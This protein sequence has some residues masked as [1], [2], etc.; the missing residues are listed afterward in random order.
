[1]T[2]ELSPKEKF[3]ANI[4]G[5]LLGVLLGGCLAFYVTMVKAPISELS[6]KVQMLSDSY[7][8]QLNQEISIARQ[9][10]F[11]AQQ[12]TKVEFLTSVVEQGNELLEDE[13]TPDEKI[14]IGGANYLREEV[15]TDLQSRQERLE[16]SAAQIDSTQRAI[17]RMQ[18]ALSNLKDLT[19]F[20]VNSISGEE[21]LQAQ[22]VALHSIGQLPWPTL[23][24]SASIEGA[25]K[26]SRADFD[27]RLGLLGQSSS[28]DLGDL[29]AFLEE[30]SVSNF[31]WREEIA[32]LNAV[33]KEVESRKI[34]V[35]FSN[36][37]RLGFGTTPAD[38]EMAQQMQNQAALLADIRDQNAA[39][40]R[41]LSQVD[42]KGDKS[43]LG[44]VIAQAGSIETPI[45]MIAKEGTVIIVGPFVSAYDLKRFRI[46]SGKGGR[47]GPL[48]ATDM[49][50]GKRYAH[51]RFSG[52]NP[53]NEP[54]W[55]WV[56][57]GKE[58]TVKVEW[59]LHR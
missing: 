48:R 4:V 57:E 15:E 51:V 23:S 10:G 52:I 3:S 26:K 49:R 6:E 25:V 32:S 1:M 37:P 12:Q 58:L 53:D 24:R 14:S 44:F 5:V 59:S 19:Q 42:R 11:L 34:R 54:L 21:A 7:V 43:D 40:A 13:A 55:I 2:R 35:P 8:D 39:L 9:Q 29:F 41:E 16:T 38:F 50:D 36:L 46:R 27:H 31:H 17:G 47:Y 20:D 56:E 45:N 33:K 22:L 28:P 30:S 18:D